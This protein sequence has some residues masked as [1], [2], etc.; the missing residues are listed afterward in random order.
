MIGNAISHGDTAAK[1]HSIINDAAADFDAKA[2]LG[3]IIDC[4]DKII[5][6]VQEA[7]IDE[8]LTPLKEQLDEI[9]HQTTDKA[10]RLE[11]SQTRLSDLLKQKENLVKQIKEMNENATFI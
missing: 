7:F 5:S 6:E 9:R 10:Q 1:V 3:T 2:F 11:A 4:K 8:L